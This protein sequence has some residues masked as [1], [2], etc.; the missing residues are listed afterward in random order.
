MA[1]ILSFTDELDILFA[2]LKIT[3]E[4][5]SKYKT[6]LKLTLNDAQKL[7]KLLN[8]PSSLSKELSKQNP[9]LLSDSEDRLKLS[10]KKINKF[11]KST[12]NTKTN[13]DDQQSAY[14]LLSKFLCAD[15][16]K[17]FCLQG[18]AGTGKTYTLMNL[19][20][21]LIQL[22][23]FKSFALVA[24]TNKA[25]SVMKTKF[26]EHIEKSYDLTYD[27]VI[28]LFETDQIS[29]QFLTLHQLLSI[30]S[31][32]AADG[33]MIW[34]NNNTTKIS[35]YEVII[36]DE[37]SMLPINI[38]D[39]ILQNI[40]STSNIKVILSGDPAQLPPLNESQSAIFRY[41]NPITFTEYKKA[42]SY[43]D[44]SI[45]TFSKEIFK[46]FLNNINSIDYFIMKQVMRTSNQDVINICLEIRNWVNNEIESPNLSPYIKT[47]NVAIFEHNLKSKFDEEWFKT[48]LIDFQK[49]NTNTIILCWTN[50]QTMSY[51]EYIR[52]NIFDVKNPKKYEIGEILILNNFYTFKS[53]SNQFKTKFNKNVAYTSEQFKVLKI[54]IY[55]K[56]I[57]LCQ[58]VHMDQIEINLKN[59]PY[60]YLL[61]QF[62]SF[63]EDIQSMQI[64][65]K[66]YELTVEKLGIEQSDL[67]KLYVIH[68]DSA[69]VYSK[70]KILIQTIIKKFINTLLDSKDKNAEKF[71]SSNINKYLWKD[72]YEN[73]IEPFADISYGYAITCHK[74]Q[75]SNFYNVFVDA[76]DIFKNTKLEEMKKC[77]YTAFSRTQN[78]L[79]ILV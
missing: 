33:S 6:N 74:A 57:L 63:K 8:L 29:V 38:I 49:K 9:L 69:Q 10:S 70:Q 3:P 26:K 54:N 78:K 16:Q 58:S 59:S 79:F 41:N 22:N 5:Y 20:L 11:I 2:D 27:E 14:K 15:N 55:K 17:I 75:G 44:P 67:Y 62:S 25:V 77:L 18:Y 24:P 4:E 52:K 45:N 39:Q 51:N 50:N 47:E 1:T 68:D 53:S 40:K 12:T 19:V 46:D 30:K 43:L 71:L 37:C 64:E 72:Y 48:C 13:T 56:K 31:D 21:K 35:S 65:F 32:Y 76:H 60:E 36:I 73:M 61:K 7:I 42:L 66:S 23:A 28:S 34:I